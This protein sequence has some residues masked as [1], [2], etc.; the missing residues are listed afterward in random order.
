MFQKSST[1]YPLIFFALIGIFLLQSSC[2]KNTIFTNEQGL[3]LRFS[4]D[5]ILFDT[6]FTSI[7]SITKQLKVYNPFDHKIEI[8]AIELLGGENSAFRLNIDGDAKL[9][10]NE[11]E[12]NAGDSI[13]IFVKVLINP[14]NQNSPFVVSDQ[15][16]F[17][18]NGHLQ[19]VELVAFGQ[20]ANY[21]IA[22]Q[23]IEGL[24]P[25]K[26]LN[27]PDGKVRW[28]KNKPYLVYGYAVVDSGYSL[29]I[30]EGTKIHFHNNSGLWI[31]KGGKIQVNGTLEQPVTFE[32]DRLDEYYRDMPGQWDRIWINEGNSDN[33]INYA[34]IR[35]GFIGIQTETLV[36]PLGNKLILKNTQISNMSGSGILSRNYHIEGTNNLVTNCGNYLLALTMGGSYSF[37]H[38]TFANYWDAAVRK[39]PSVY[40]NNYSLNYSNESTVYPFESFFGNCIIDGLKSEEL[41]MDFNTSSS[42]VIYFDHNALKTQ[43][44]ISNNENY[45]QTLLNPTNL[46]KD[47]HALNFQLDSLSPAIDKASSIISL[48]APLDILGK[49][50]SI[51]PDLGVFEFYPQK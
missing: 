49:S 18:T 42:P 23:N 10:V 22:D 15:I 41:E 46:F 35:N 17:N 2:K 33:I 26:I 34:I 20:N 25:F 21:I 40:F 12:L 30:E 44:D 6:V 16:Q 45:E 27:S 4:S 7:G 24:P 36:E 51:K 28:N 38:S 47:T 37:I 29:I 11:L 39:T 9:K 32:G 1:Y 3:A 14:N 43:L 13:F 50:R 5:S 48:K 31:Y 19:T 8:D